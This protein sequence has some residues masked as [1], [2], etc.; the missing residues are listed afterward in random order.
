MNYELTVNNEGF[1]FEL[2]E[3]QLKQLFELQEE[4]IGEI[5]KIFELGNVKP[6]HINYHYKYDVRDTMTN[7]G[8]YS[9]VTPQF[10]D[11]DKANELCSTISKG[12]SITPFIELV[13]DG[14]L[15]IDGALDEDFL[16]VKQAEI[17]NNH[18]KTQKDRAKNLFLDLYRESDV[19][20]SDK[21][22]KYCIQWFVPRNKTVTTEIA[23]DVKY[24]V[25]VFSS[26]KAIEIGEKYRDELKWYFTEYDPNIVMRVKI[27]EKK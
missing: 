3:K 12:V 19:S 15:Y 23:S 9:Y 5:G 6:N 1:N 11:A 16:T 22:S 26:G 17:L 25:P 18:I 2:K 24:F 10:K 7:E 27:E 14:N 20:W 8:V 4:K 13:Y 21:G